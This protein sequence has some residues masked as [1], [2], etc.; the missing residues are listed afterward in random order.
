MA[1][2]LTFGLTFGNMVGHMIVAH[3]VHDK[4]PY[5]NVNFIA[6]TVGTILANWTTLTGQ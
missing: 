4:F 3:V 6:F 5:F 1:V 2:L